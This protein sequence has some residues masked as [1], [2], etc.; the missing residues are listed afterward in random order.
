MYAGLF[1][2]DNLG[3]ET[4]RPLTDRSQLA[5]SNLFLYEV[6]NFFPNKFGVNQDLSSIQFPENFHNKIET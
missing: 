6:N 5:F 3:F 1:G 2:P 4:W